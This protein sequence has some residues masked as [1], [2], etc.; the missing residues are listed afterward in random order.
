VHWPVRRW[1][2]PRRSPGT[3][4]A[5]T[6]SEGKEMPDQ[7]ADTIS[8]MSIDECALMDRIATGDPSA[9]ETLY[10]RFHPKL[11][12]LL[13]RLIGRREGLEEIIN[14]IF[15]DV[16][17]GAKNFRE[18]PLV[19]SAWMFGI[20]YR[21]ALEYLC[22]Q[23]SSSAW[24]SMRHPREQAK[25]ALDDA[26]IGDALSQGLRAV[27][28]EQRL[29]LLLTYQMG[30]GLEEIAAITGVSAATVNARMLCARE[31][32]RCLFPDEAPS[33]DVR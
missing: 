22:Q 24:P 32:L 30:Y 18:A 28:F 9:L 33:V 25:D 12:H 21:K 15:V 27:P 29:V 11:A 8:G 5:L 23:R 2:M 3:Q 6:T 26:E 31:Q 14:D 20:A 17:K 4:R 10:Y 1:T 19:V 13:W 16:W 7:L